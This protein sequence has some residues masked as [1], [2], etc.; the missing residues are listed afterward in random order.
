M[1]ATA[2]K[3]ATMREYRFLVPLAPEGEY[4][5]YHKGVKWDA[6]KEGLVA[7]AGGFTDAG[8]VEG[9]WKDGDKLIQEPCR[10]FFVSVQPEMKRK[11]FA[12]FELLC[13]KFSQQC[14]YVASGGKSWLV[15][16]GSSNVGRADNQWAKEALGLKTELFD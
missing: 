12:I 10:Q 11:L 3:Q 13:P 4:A 5:V 6:H 15:R 16:Q 8:E 2:T 14:I 9:A 7:V 1:T